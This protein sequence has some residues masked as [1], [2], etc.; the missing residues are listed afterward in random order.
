[1]LKALQAIHANLGTQSVFALQPFVVSIRQ[2]DRHALQLQRFD[3]FEVLTVANKSKL[4]VIDGQHRVHAIRAFRDF[5]Y[6]VQVSPHY[7][8]VTVGTTDKYFLYGDSS[9]P[10]TEPEGQAWRLVEYQ[11]SQCDTPVAIFTTLD[12]PQ[13]RQM[14]HETP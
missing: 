14:F 11:F 1:M 13:E 6:E 7:P 9:T 12:L 10:R 3:N 2:H 4:W 8:E 5:L